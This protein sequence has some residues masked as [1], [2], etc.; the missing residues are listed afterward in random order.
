[1]RVSTNGMQGHEGD[2]YRYFFLRARNVRI[3]FTRSFIFFFSQSFMH[4]THPFYMI[5]LHYKRN[6][7]KA[8]NIPARIC[9]YEDTPRLGKNKYLLRIIYTLYMYIHK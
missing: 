2:C 7:S 6:L 9:L 5:L 4:G 8:F 3:F 1:M